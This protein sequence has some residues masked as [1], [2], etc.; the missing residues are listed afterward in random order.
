MIRGGAVL[1]SILAI[2]LAVGMQACAQAPAE[3]PGV[4]VTVYNQNYAVVK[5]VRE[6]NITGKEPV[7]FRDVAQHID[8]T[9]V[10]FESLTDP[11]AVVQEQNYEY[12]LVSADKLLLKYLDQDIKIL[13]KSGGKYE[14]KLLSFDEGQL[15]MQTSQGIAMVQRADNI[16][17]V[18]FGKLPEGLLTRPTLVWKVGTEK[19]GKQ[20]V[21]IAYQTTEMDW[22][23]DYNV[24]SNKDDTSVDISGWVT[25]NNRSGATYK[26]AKLKLIA[27]DV[28]RIQPQPVYER[29]ARGGEFGAAQAASMPE[30][31]AFF[32]YHLYTF[33]ELTTLADNQVKQLHLLNAANV[34]VKKLYRYE[35]LTAPFYGGT[36]TG[37]EWGRTENKKVKVILEIANV[38]SNH[39][40][41]PLPAGKVRVYKMDEK[42]GSM[43]FI[44]ED[45]IEHTKATDT[46][47][48]YVGNAFDLNGE[49][50]VMDFKSERGRNWMQETV[51]FTLTSAKKEPVTIEVEEKLSRAKNWTL[52]FENQGQKYEKVDANT[53]RFKVDLPA[54]EGDKPGKT[55]VKYVVD[56]TW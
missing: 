31:R 44:G 52:T 10:I 6:E 28:R 43:E 3:K 19:P 32:E 21:R 8:P 20:L 25:I 48:L 33:P 49:R 22:R 41:V 55:V 53:I 51:Q 54:M 42:A 56:Y 2:T 11:K 40:G 34:A 35:G 50:K 26:D 1:L 18:Q 29:R 14:G 46:V 39:L 24:V 30:E 13:T 5:E 12:D 36:M 23:A 45:Q 15:V 37:A 27:G 7:R 16:Q 4:A 17:D 47:K 9:S 38:E